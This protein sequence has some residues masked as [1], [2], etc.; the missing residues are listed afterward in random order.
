MTVYGARTQAASQRPAPLTHNYDKAAEGSRVAWNT[1][2]LAKVF[3]GYHA[4]DAAEVL[5]FIEANTDAWL[6]FAL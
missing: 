6:R 3:V 2:G 5:E 1:P 4:E